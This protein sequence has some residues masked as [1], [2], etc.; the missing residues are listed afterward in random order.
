VKHQ[1]K[2]PF[3]LLFCFYGF[4]LIAQTKPDSL[5]AVF[6]NISLSDTVRLKAANRV[7]RDFINNNPDSAILLAQK[8]LSLAQKSGQKKYEATAL[9]I[10][11]S[12]FYNKGNY[13]N[14]LEYFLKDLWICD[15]RG[16]KKGMGICYNNLGN[17]YY[18]HTNYSKAEDYYLKALKKFIENGDE[19]A[20]AT[21]YGNIGNVYCMEFQYPK[22]LEYFYK[23]KDISEK[24]GDKEGLSASYG[25]IGVVYLNQLNYP[26]ALK[27]FLKQKK[28]CEET[29]NKKSLANSYVNIGILFKSQTNYPEALENYLKALK[30]QAEIGDIHGK[31]VCF[32]NLSFLYS[33]IPDYKKSLQFSDSAITICKEI[34]DLENERLAYQ[35]RALIYAKKNMYKEAY[36]NHIK[37]KSLTDSIF[38]IYNT[39]QLSDSKTRYEVEKKESELKTQAEAQQTINAEEKKRQQ[40]VIYAIAGLLF[41][42]AF[43]AVFMFNRFKVTQKQKGIIEK[44]KETVEEQKHLVE[45]K[46]KEIVDSIT[47]AKR[48]QQA[49]LPSNEELKK[50]LPD[51]FLLYKPKDIIAGDFY[52]MEHLDEI[53]Y[54]AAADSTGHGVPGAMVSVVCSNA[55]NRAVKEFGLRETGKILDKTRELVLE[56][57]EKSGEEIKDGMDI[58]L[59][60]IDKNKKQISWS[61]A[62]N[63]LWYIVNSIGL[64]GIEKKEL[65]EIVADKQPIGKTDHSKPFTTHYLEL[66]KGDIFYLMT[67][68]YPDQFGGS[69]GKK[70]KYKQLEE[71]LFSLNGEEL[72]HQSEILNAKF[73]EWKGNLEQVDDVTIIGIKI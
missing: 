40:V 23:Y 36:E 41:L 55:I 51:Y 9:G 58:S 61:G 30:L 14:A 26:K 33:E 35:K 38:N 31:A 49:I 17:I 1:L 27:C 32:V 10:I 54:I 18:S 57:F 48:L 64:N 11:A 68:G 39:K 22:A 44:Q 20:E 53:I 42:M 4:Y 73:E 15:E 59:L 46:Q 52:W 50:Y 37:F 70:F 66:K 67:D 25:N 34:G 21:C 7:A 6:N 3:I 13:S 62:N 28:I 12:A 2:T 29:G 69:K 71:L 65:K 16:D 63:H 56:T 60:S 24:N 5:L 47:Y 45:E 72:T 43:F 19:M 8:Q